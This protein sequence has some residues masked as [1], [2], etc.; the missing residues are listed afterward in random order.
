MAH[1]TSPY[2]HRF[3]HSLRRVLS[4]PVRLQTYRNL[5][6]LLLMFPLGTLYLTIV[7]TV[8]ALSFAY[9]GVVAVPLLLLFML[10][11]AVGLA[12]FERT[13]ARILL[14]VDISASQIDPELPISARIKQLVIDR[15]TWAAVFYLLSA[16]VV[17]RALFTLL[18]SL[19]VT[20]SS[21]VLTPLYYKYAPTGIYLGPA[22]VLTFTPELRFGWNNLLV[23]LATTI[24]IETFRVTTLSEALLVACVGAALLLLSLHLFNSLAWLWGRY[25][26]TMLRVPPYWI[27]LGR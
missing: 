26:K 14:R 7:G 1:W 20:P 8:V 23:G 13:L 17:S 18:I 27:G 15:W 10:L 25:M 4:A 9:V 24:R 11:L 19:L 22:P 12:A 5:L 21:L 16:F 3:K 2:S 6:Y